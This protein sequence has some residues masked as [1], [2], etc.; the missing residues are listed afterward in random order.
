[1]KTLLASLKLKI[2]AMFQYKNLTEIKTFI[3][4]KARA[5]IEEQ[6]RLEKLS[7]SKTSYS[8]YKP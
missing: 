2:P 5:L 8:I 4:S 3:I 6:I 1:M 7:K